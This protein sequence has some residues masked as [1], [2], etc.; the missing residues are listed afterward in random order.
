MN[1]GETEQVL[2]HW[3][4]STGPSVWGGEL[5]T[6]PRFK[7]YNFYRIYTIYLPVVN[8]GMRFRW[9]LVGAHRCEQFSGEVALHAV[10]E[11]SDHLSGRAKPS[12]NGYGCD[13]VE[14]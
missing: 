8:S 7:Y 1:G 5:W 12:R 3:K 14:A 10:R 2:H 9:K 4:D 13:Q 11:D 6:A